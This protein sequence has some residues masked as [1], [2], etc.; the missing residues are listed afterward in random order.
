V[1]RGLLVE[2]VL[3]GDV[4]S[5]VGNTTALLGGNADGGAHASSLNNDA[6]WSC[7]SGDEEV[8]AEGLGDGESDVCVGGSLDVEWDVAGCGAEFGGVHTA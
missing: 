3:G 1:A 4:E 6:A 7:A 5:T 2:S 8:V